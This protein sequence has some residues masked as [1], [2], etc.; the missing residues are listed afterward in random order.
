[1]VREMGGD[2]SPPDNLGAQSSLFREGIVDQGR[3]ET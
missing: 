2:F 1:M 3:G